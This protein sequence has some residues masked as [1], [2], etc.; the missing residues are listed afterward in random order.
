VGIHLI[1]G[2]GFT[3]TDGAGQPPVMLINQTVARSGFLGENPLGAHVYIAGG[4]QPIEI[5]GIVETFASSVWTATRSRRCSSTFANFPHPPS[6]FRSAAYRC[7]MPRTGDR[8]SAVIGSIRAMVRQVEPEATV[9][10]I[11]ALNNWCPTRFRD[12]GFT[13]SSW[14]SLQSSPSHWRPSAS[15]A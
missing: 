6:R 9:D 15:T 12:R 3:E 5:V 8:Q 1:A 4:T 10:D 14:A 7:R 13:L 11:A 2:R